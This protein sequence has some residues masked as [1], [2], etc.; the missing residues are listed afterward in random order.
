MS[1][2]T[3]TAGVSSF[4]SSS[5]GNS[6]APLVIPWLVTQ[7]ALNP[8]APVYTHEAGRFRYKASRAYHADVPNG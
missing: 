2:V 7:S 4:N 6:F 8:Y 1:I 3:L 5:A